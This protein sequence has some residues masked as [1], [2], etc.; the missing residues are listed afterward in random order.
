MSALQD[1]KLNPDTDSF[2]IIKFTGV[3]SAA[4][5]IHPVNVSPVQL[6]GAAEML[7]WQAGKQMEEAYQQKHSH[8][9]KIAVPEPGTVLLNKDA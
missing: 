4:F 6:I 7:K 3:Q 5:E 2:I 1:I 9:P 8:Q